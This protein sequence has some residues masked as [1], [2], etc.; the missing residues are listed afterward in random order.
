ME[1]PVL[2][3]PLSSLNENIKTRLWDVVVDNNWTPYVK[4]DNF[5]MF[6]YNYSADNEFTQNEINWV[7]SNG[8]QVWNFE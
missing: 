2:R 6:N 8:G 1:Y 4:N 5:W 3:I 7:I